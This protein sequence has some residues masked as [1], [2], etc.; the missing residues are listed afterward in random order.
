[1][2]KHILL[3]I[4]VLL[5]SGTL[6]AQEAKKAVPK[7]P[8]LR[9]VDY[10]SDMGEG[11]YR[12]H[13]ARLFND[14]EFDADG[15][16]ETSDD[17]V[18]GWEFSLDEPLSPSGPF[19]NTQAPSH[20]YYGGIIGVHANQPRARLTE[21]FLNSNHELRDDM[22]FMSNQGTSSKRAGNT[23]RGWG[24]W[25]WR[26]SDFLNHGDKFKVTFDD[27]SLLAVHISR[28]WD[29]IDGG[30]WVVRDGDTFYISEATFGTP[31]DIEKRGKSERLSW[32]LNPTKTRWA[33]YTPKA[34]YNVRFNPDQAR[35]A[36]QNFENVS[37]TG[38]YLFKDSKTLGVISVKW[39]SFETWAVVDVPQR[40]SL[41]L[42]MARIDEGNL[43]MA[44]TKDKLSYKEWFEVYN[45]AVSNQYTMDLDHRGYVFDRDGDMGQMDRGQSDL[46]AEA[47]ATDMT[48]LDAVL[49]CNALSEL[50][51]L[52][53]CYYLDASHRQVLRKI[54]ERNRP[55]RY[56]W[57]PD[58]HVKWD[59]DG[60]RLPTGK[61]WV[62]SARRSAVNNNL[63]GEYE[64]IWGPTD[65]SP[66]VIEANT[67]KYYAM[68]GAKVPDSFNNWIYPGGASP[69]V[70]FRPIR[71]LAGST[72]NLVVE[73]LAEI[74]WV[75]LPAEGKADERKER[76]FDW[77]GDRLVKIENGNYIRGDE[78]RVTVSDYY[79]SKT[80]VP[81]RV[82]NIVY[83]AA[84]PLGYQFD[85]DGDMGSM[86][87][88]PGDT[89]HAIEEPVT[90]I[91]WYDCLVW[92]NALSELTG[93]TPVYYTDEA[94]TQVFRTALPW[95]IRMVAE[96]H[97]ADHVSDIPI[98]TKWEANGFRLPTWAEW[99]IA[100]RAG[101]GNYQ[102]REGKQWTLE[103]ANAR[104]HPVDT[105]DPNP[106]SI[107]NLQGNVSEWLHDVPV[108][109]YYRPEN[110]KGD[111]RDSLFGMSIA[112]G[113]F[114]TPA[115]FDS[116]RAKEKNRKSAGWPWLGFR[117]VRCET[118]AHS[119]KPFVPKVVL[120]VKAEDYDPLQGRTFRANMRRNG[121]YA[122]AGLPELNGEKWR[123]KTGGPVLSSPVVVDGV[124]YVGSND[125]YF[126]AI[127]VTTGR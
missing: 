53:P 29:D 43:S 81:F 12:D 94:K 35:F 80:E 11:I 120:D 105:G 73:Q 84:L 7:Q 66:S 16:G 24:V 30:R 65:A 71:V 70:G 61:E 9:I 87:W 37:A 41:H 14:I 107:Y 27:N 93:R 5:F 58:V 64:F 89:K 62:W 83:Q 56:G 2:N 79:I 13:T 26:K 117:I 113:N 4:I 60:Y 78:A 22:N 6:F 88:N 31:D 44:V 69:L 106:W 110:P 51:G 63:A 102:Q 17:S 40:P 103:N 85:R 25:L 50:E 96:G 109:D 42:D 3:S 115:S 98:Y 124:V 111:M 77:Q 91:G 125:G 57:K 119:T 1:M 92:C 90:D 99:Y 97:G 76:Q 72:E 55:E 86:D 100:L 18:S 38:F 112:G 126:Y 36:R 45:W 48:W 59:A 127:D 47:T 46:S 49:W 8:N 23:I 74:P 82:W 21:G 67:D 20:R 10:G 108:N 121:R 118:G 52:T 33:V 122:N 39:H 101:D 28:Y 95:R 68:G 54:R 114:N 15:D 75:V 32:W 104:T 123:F 116:G 34:P 19:Y